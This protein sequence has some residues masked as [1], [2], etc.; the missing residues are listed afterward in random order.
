MNAANKNLS[1][2]QVCISVGVI[3][4]SGLKVSTLAARSCLFKTNDV[5]S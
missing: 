4:A 3:R 1:G 5:F 2:V